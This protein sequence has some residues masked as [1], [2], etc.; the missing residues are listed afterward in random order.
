MSTDIAVR[1][2]NLPMT[3]TDDVFR[4]GKAFA[5]AGVLGARNDAEG[6]MA[7]KVVQ[8]EGLV[9]AA[10]RYNIRQGNIGLKYQALAGDFI[11][12]GGSYRVVRR[13]AEC[14]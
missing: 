7:V 3:N 2:N 11:R 6:V 10:Q 9:R 4:L 5:Q 1:D 12:A 14:A 13:D 8:E